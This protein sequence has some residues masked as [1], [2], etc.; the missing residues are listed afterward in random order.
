M[1]KMDE[2]EMMPMPKKKGRGKKMSKR[3]SGKSR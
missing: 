2:K 1:Q 3:K